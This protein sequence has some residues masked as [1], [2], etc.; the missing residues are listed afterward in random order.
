MA[1]LPGPGTPPERVGNY[2]ILDRLGEGGMGVVFLAFD[3]SL[4]RRVALK[5][6]KQ[7]TPATMERLRQEA[8]LHARVEHP[9]VCRLYQVAEW[10]G[11]PYL[12]MQL[13]SGQTL[14]QVAPTLP[15]ATQLRLMATLADGVHAAHRQ[16]LIHRDLKPANL[17][18]EPDEAGGWRPFVMDFGLARDE[19]SGSLTEAGMMLGSPSYMA[20]EQVAGGWID[21][22][23]DV[24]GLGAAL[25]EVLTG[26][27]PFQG[28]AAEILVQ[29]QTQDPPR[30]RELRPEL[31]RDLE[32]VLQTCLAKDPARRYPSAAAFRDDLLRLLD[33]EP[34]KARRASLLEHLGLWIRR[35]RLASGLA[36]LVL[37]SILASSLVWEV[38]QRRAQSR[39]YWAQRFG[40]EAMRMESLVRFGRMLPSHDVVR[41]F[42]QVRQ[43][44]EEV[45]RQMALVPLS[46]GPGHFTLGEGSLLLGDP[47]TASRELERAWQLGQRSAEVSLALG[48]SLT[49]LYDREY[50][51]SLGLLEPGKRAARQQ[52]IRRDL[53]DRALDHLRRARQEL[54]AGFSREEEARLALADLRFDD[55]A[56][57]A[58]AA[59]EAEPW[60]YDAL[61]YLAKALAYRAREAGD[62][63]R[64]GQAREDFERALEVLETPLRVGPSDDR[65]QDARKFIWLAGASLKLRGLDR[66][67]S[68]EHALEAS[69]RLHLQNSSRMD[70]L[71]AHALILV[72]LGREQASRGRDPEPYFQRA[73]AAM[74]K[75]TRAP[76]QG[77]G[78]YPSAIR[79]RALDR[80]ASLAHTRASRALKGKVDPR[81]FLESGLEYCRQALTEGLAQWETHQN[82]A[83]LHMDQAEDQKARGQES[84][85]ALQR[86]VAA[87]RDCAQLNPSAA[88]WSNL[89]E[90]LNRQGERQ[91]AR[92]EDP[93]PTLEMARQALQEASSLAPGQAVTLGSQGDTD[94]LEARWLNRPGQDPL[95]ALTRAQ[96]AFEGAQAKDPTEA[97]FPSSLAQVH[98][99][100]A[101]VRQA[102]GEDGASEAR[103]SLESGRRALALKTDQDREVRQAMARARKVLTKGSPAPNRIGQRRK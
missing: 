20:P 54:G 62:A 42:D 48:H 87:L 79:A 58:E 17:M 52:E 45:R 84:L 89:A 34:V 5:W 43:R 27:P 9:A 28:Q 85:E 90:L 46:R 77:P 78:S 49:D 29:V 51:A 82:L 10:E 36:A 80:L 50:A 102:K 19:A 92:G 71:N 44:M 67:N 68:L 91:L 47:E 64:E 61:F 6:L 69:E 33:G 40:Q 83:F 63:G 66:L 103:Q 7:A 72:Q 53:R 81:P 99:L 8:H 13:I 14:D 23:T 86:S 56:R 2:R 11:W 4:G 93:R 75:V 18:V 94:L 73:E 3:E 32:T 74:Q 88:S 65:L 21:A 38:G 31:P 96:A 26:R 30:L 39:A 15:L 12:V 22:R 25:F 41:E 60:R 37:L 98:A 95:P 55:A 76:R 57:L 59:F 100:A 97:C 24:Y 16:G 35:N 70:M 1:E 101:E